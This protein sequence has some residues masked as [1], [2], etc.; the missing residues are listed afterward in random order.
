[1]YKF[2]SIEQFR[3]TIRNLEYRFRYVGKDENG[4]SVYDN[5]K[6][7]PTIDLLGT[8]KL[9]GTNS[10]IVVN[11]DFTFEYQSRT[12]ELSIG[13]DNYGF[14][15]YA[16]QALVKG[17]FVDIIS[18][19][20]PHLQGNTNVFFGEWCGKGIQKGV[21]ISQVDKRFVIFAI[22]TIDSEGKEMW[23]SHEDISKVKNST[24]DVYNVFQFETYN[25]SID[26]NNPALSQNQLIDLTNK[27][28]A[29]CPAGDFFEVEGIGEGVVWRIINEDENYSLRSPRYWFKT[30]GIKHQSSNKKNKVLIEIEPE[31]QNSINE[32]V[33]YACTENRMKQMLN[34]TLNDKHINRKYIG[35][36]LKMVNQDIIKEEIDVLR[37]SNLSYRDVNKFITR[38]AK[39]WFFNKEKER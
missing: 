4:D 21:A 16:S 26:L 8:V 32:F 34:D 15:F 14:A 13:S 6:E 12:R 1:M 10:S 22:K 27:V 25:I 19:T 38:K 28:E 20:L 33:S 17:F 2:P 30:K 39:N 29:K 5:T 11:P 35:P 18:N 9:H 23:L 7:L 3:T 37:K 24:L 36:F 31:K